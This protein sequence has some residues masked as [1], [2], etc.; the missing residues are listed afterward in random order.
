MT[1]EGRR[2]AAVVFTDMVG[3]STFSERNE[4]LAMRL[5]DAHNS[6][7]RS[8]MERHG[9]REVKTIGDSFLIEFPSAL[10]AVRFAVETQD[11]FGRAGRESSSGE[12]VSVRIGIHVG[13]VISRDGDLFGDAVNIASRIVEVAQGGQ[14]CISGNVYD[15][16]RNKM[17]VGM[18]KLPSQK[19]RG[20]ESDVDLYLLVPH[21]E[22][23]VEARPPAL[24]DRIAV[25][26]FANI[27][28]DPNDGYFAEGLTEELISQLSGVKGLRVI[29][30]T[31]VERYKAAPKNARQ[32]GAELNVSHLLEGSVRKAGN[33]IRI[34]AHLVDT[35]S[36]EEV[37]SE[38]Y[39]KDLVDVFSIQSDIASRVAESLKVR[40]LGAE[41]ERMQSKETESVAAYIA[42][43]K[44]R[45]LLRDGTE[46]SAHLAREQFE[47][48]IKADEN[49]AKAYA[50]LA[51]TMVL[52]GDYLFSPVPKALEEANKYVRKALS[53]D[54]DLAEARVSLGSLLL[55]DYRFAD[56]E[57]ELR[58]ALETNPSY[59]QGHYW[60]SICLQCFGRQAEATKESLVAEELDPLSSSVAL[61]AFYRL[62][63]AG[64]LEEARRR[65]SKLEEIDRESPLV[66]ETRM[67][68]SFAKKD[69]DAAMAS[70]KRMVERDPA[71]PYLDMDLA[72][73]YAVTGRRDEALKLVEKLKE[74]PEDQRIRGQLLA[75]LF[76]GLGDIDSALDWIAY[77][78]SK[79]EFF[80]GWVRGDPLFEP[81]RKDP[82][83]RELLRS[84]GLQS[85]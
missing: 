5:L 63:N 4:A 19:L 57:K 21:A 1:Q 68:Y 20:I 64:R 54:P 2:L 43:L 60:Y 11:D 8:V 82:R 6:L 25:M 48:A 3:Y 74:I 58:K 16:V 84:V 17:E 32:I 10:E 83:F 36:Q 59:P 70:L 38:R 56:A 26:P 12:A 66:D 27:S 15:Q 81:A 73:I 85:E 61:T 22:D 78:L 49:Y 39:E 67:V 41:R 40:L 71:D 24:A 37:W 18:E 42:Y 55:F 65:I 47:L 30:R 14:V 31:S 53:L 50:G 80:V 45:S 44:G 34:T 29:A 23:P 76:L 79:K 72:Y 62:M 77:G 69:W 51:D 33:R 13:D 35:E 75:L 52:L 46:R 9:G 7:I 28:P